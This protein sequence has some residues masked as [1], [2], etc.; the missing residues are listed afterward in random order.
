MRVF[1]LIFDS[2]IELQIELQRAEAEL[3]KQTTQSAVRVCARS[4]MI[5]RMSSS[6]T[7]SNFLFLFFCSF[8]SRSRRPRRK[9]KNCKPS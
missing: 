5:A 1:C 3:L 7:F 4:E 8:L 6:Y 2:V 9:C